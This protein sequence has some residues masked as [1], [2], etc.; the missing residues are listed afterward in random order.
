MRTPKVASNLGTDSSADQ[1]AKPQHLVHR[2]LSTALACVA[3]T[4][5][6]VVS[7]APAS[8]HHGWDGFETDNLVYLAGTVSSDGT[9]GEPHSHF[10]VQVDDEL[11][12]HTP[13]LEIPEDLQAPEDSD[14]VNAALAYTGDNDELEIIIAPPAWSGPW[15]LDRALR[16]GE[17]VQAVGYINRS[18]AGLFRPV[19]FW[20][21]DDQVPV[22]QVLG[23]T[24]P[25]HAP[26][27]GEQPDNEG[28]S[29]S[30][31]AVQDPLET[32]S[33]TPES[34]TTTSA[35]SGGGWAVWTIFAA[36]VVL[37]VGAGVLYL[38]R[39]ARK[40]GRDDA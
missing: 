26:L 15:G 25:V 14:R 9:W 30:P 4:T 21:G 27:P 22:N 32:Q 11:P 36:L 17:R 33:T 23:N 24:L 7:A 16:V 10:D 12:A 8:G 19:V 3:A 1:P 39:Q 38:R 31:S 18:D 35:E 6:A 34:D 37:A 5:L 29:A 2:V 13:K 40:N 20:Y 28:T